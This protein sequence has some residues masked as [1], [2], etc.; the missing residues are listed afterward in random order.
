MTPIDRT[1]SR[2]SPTKFRVWQ[3]GV[4]IIFVGLAFLYNLMTPI[5][6]G[7]DEIWHFTFANYL[8]QGR[9]LP[10]LAASGADIRL[11]NAGHTPLYHLLAA[12]I[13]API[14]RSDFPA[15]FRF[16]LASPSITPG[17]FSDRPNL[18]IHTS[19]EDFPYRQTTLAVHLARLLSTV[20]GI[21]TVLG[22]ATVARF[23]VK[24]DELALLAMSVTA[25]I[26]QF[27]YESGI[28]NND[29]LA[30]AGTTWLLAALL[31]LIQTLELPARNRAW[32]GRAASAGVLLGI[33]LLSK[34]GMVA[35]APFP[36]LVLGLDWFWKGRKRAR[37][38]AGSLGIVYGVA[39]VIAGWWYVRNWVLYGDPLAWQQW[40]AQAGAGRIPP[41][42][43]D[44]LHDMAGLFGM[45]WA[46][47]T[48]R[49]DR[50][51]GW[52]FASLV[53]LAAAGLLQRAS[54]HEW[55]EIYVPGLLGAL[56]TFGL[57]LLVVVRYSF[58]VYDIP[59]RLMHPA[60]AGVTL[61]M[62][63]GLTGWSH[64][65]WRSLIIGG[66]LGTLF[67]F[68]LLALWGAIRPAYARPVLS[69]AKLPDGTTPVA[70]RFGGFL[71][72]VGYRLSETRLTPG[73]SLKVWTY[74]RS[75]AAQPHQIP[76]LHGT[77]ALV[78]PD[79]RV[80][81]HTEI[82][83]GTTVY[84]SSEWQPGEIIAAE[85]ILPL[86]SDVE[87]P[88]AAQI[89]LGVIAGGTRILTEMGETIVAGQI[90][91][92][93][94]SVETCPYSQPVQAVFDGKIQLLGYGLESSTL[95]F[96]W[97]ALAALP[98]DYTIFIHGY[99]ADGSLAGVTDAPPYRGNYP[100]SHWEVGEQVE[101]RH[102]LP[103][104]ADYLMVGW[105][106]LDTG[107]RLALDEMGHSELKLVL[108]TAGSKTGQ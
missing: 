43:S 3:T 58:S 102:P 15:G 2:L 53:G 107:A 41:T 79:G 38:Y 97:Q 98:V 32:T 87:T 90:A 76:D 95:V 10:V 105:Y 8:A 18:F 45:F 67:L 85:A 89:Q 69:S 7:P 48:L 24:D 19:H 5:F 66:T 92:N 96:C 62:A 68:N 81:G 1:P 106:R 75:L 23:V 27:A 37:F 71:E 22:V 104:N 52:L 6:E 35:L 61:V 47:L 60:L 14:D 103:A 84:P 80:I 74:W 94:D 4:I 40:Y 46:D 57:V 55:P 9:G 39:L 59:G 72:I 70:V 91:V 17:S 65:R 25:L 13:I 101:D 93:R 44:F 56:C 54:R 31:W 63:L 11:R 50:Q 20:L 16:N 100:T 64:R 73:R 34:V 51:W 36:A 108:P 49:L 12:V 86:G 30:I 33:T 77:V 42:G 82:R 29:A 26:P 78:R 83:L 99:H 28:F 21:F 88:V